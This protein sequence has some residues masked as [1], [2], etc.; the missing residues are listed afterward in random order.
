MFKNEPSPEEVNEPQR[1][2]AETDKV[3]A[4]Q[5]LCLIKLLLSAGF[6]DANERSIPSLSSR[7]FRERQK[8]EP[9]RRECSENEGFRV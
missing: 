7:T 4:L 5:I 8:T 9:V 1:G 6:D 3:N 2:H